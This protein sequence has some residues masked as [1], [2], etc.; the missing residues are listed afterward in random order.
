MT[1]FQE[2]TAWEMENF[3]KRVQDGGEMTGPVVHRITIE[4]W[5]GTVNHLTND[6]DDDGMPDGEWTEWTENYTLTAH[7]DKAIA[8]AGKCRIGIS[9]VIVTV[10][11]DGV[12]QR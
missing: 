2:M 4:R 12:E 3:I 11:L 10:M 9:G 5:A 1:T 8:S 6:D 7:M